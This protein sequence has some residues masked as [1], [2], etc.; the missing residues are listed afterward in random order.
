MSILLA[1]Q[2]S[3][4]KHVLDDL[5]IRDETVYPPAY[6]IDNPPPPKAHGAIYQ[7]GHEVSLYEDTVAGRIGD[8][9]TIRLEE[10]TQ[11]EKKAKM[12]TNKTATNSF[13]SPTLFGASVGVLNF[14]TDTDQQFDGEGENRQQNR[15]VGT[16]SVTVTRV[17]SNGNLMIQGESW[18]TINQGREY[19]RLTGIVRREDIE[20]NNT[21]SSQRVADARI[22]YSGGGQELNTTRGG[23]VTQFLTKF[24]PY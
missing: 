2:I 16:I 10:M 14:Q 17:L 5:G 1:T 22:M 20:P 13:D 6:P 7:S 4:C 9:L 12:K 21:I 11:G 3:G 15:L 18:L 24:F 8:I 19:I 23:F